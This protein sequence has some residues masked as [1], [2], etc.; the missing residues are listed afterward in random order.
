M[1]H[2]LAS[3]RLLLLLY[4]ARLPVVMEIRKSELNELIKKPDT[5]DETFIIPEQPWCKVDKR[6]YEAYLQG[7][8]QVLDIMQ[9]SMS[10]FSF[11]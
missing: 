1:C 7:C 3:F 5:G 4:S 11:K 10:R 9:Y 6:T 2:V 8:I